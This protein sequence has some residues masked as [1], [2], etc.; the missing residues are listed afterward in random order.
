MQI[1]SAGLIIRLL[2]G[3]KVEIRTGGGSLTEKPVDSPNLKDR[4]IG[5]NSRSMQFEVL[6]Q[7]GGVRSAFPVHEPDRI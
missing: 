7:R 2:E 1:P 5:L 3:I 6:R 4:R